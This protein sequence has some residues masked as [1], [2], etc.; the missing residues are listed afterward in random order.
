MN[1]ANTPPNT[2]AKATHWTQDPSRCPT[3][4]FRYEVVLTDELNSMIDGDHASK[5]SS[6]FSL[7]ERWLKRNPGLVVKVYDRMARVGRPYEWSNVGTEAGQVAWGV[8]QLK[9]S[10]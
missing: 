9:G 3:T 8:T 10:T 5:R 2:K 1:T 6:A 7:G 4:H